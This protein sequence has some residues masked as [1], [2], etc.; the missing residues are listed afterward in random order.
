MPEIKPMTTHSRRIAENAAVVAGATL[1]SRILG[2]ARDLV[3]AYALGAGLFA[4]AFFVAFRLPNLLRRLFGEGSLTMAFVPVFTRIRTKD[5]EAEAETDQETAVA[6]GASPYVLYDSKEA[7][8]RATHYVV[9]I[10]PGH[11]F[12]RFKHI[13]AAGGS[14]EDAAAALHAKIDEF[15]DRL[16]S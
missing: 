7:L 4:D 16:T 10:V 14:V 5:G 6:M 13:V 15:V 3:I 11:V 12:E 1:L 9:N 8:E 2:F